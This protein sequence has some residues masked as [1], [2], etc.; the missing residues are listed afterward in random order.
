VA[1]IGRLAP[2][3]A[4]AVFAVGCSSGLLIQ[5]M[6]IRANLPPDL[7]REIAILKEAWRRAPS[8]HYAFSKEALA[9]LNFQPA[10]GNFLKT[11]NAIT[12]FTAYPH[13]SRPL[14]SGRPAPEPEVVE[15]QAVLGVAEIRSVT[16]EPGRNVIQFE[17]PEHKSMK[18]LRIEIF[19]GSGLDAASLTPIGSIKLEDESAGPAGEAVSINPPRVIQNYFDTAVEPRKPYTYRLRAIGRMTTPPDKKIPFIES[20]GQAAFRVVRVPANAQRCGSDSLEFAGAQSAAKSVTSTSNCD[21][22]FSGLIGDISPE[23]IP[24]ERRRTDY[25]ATF[26]VRVW[27]RNEWRSATLQTS[28]GEGLKGTVLIRNME[29]NRLE[30]AEFDT[31]LEFCEVTWGRVRH[32]VKVKEP[33][34]DASGDPKLD[35]VGRPLLETSEKENESSLTEIALVRDLVSGK[36]MELSKAM[37]SPATGRPR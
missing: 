10:D 24:Q 36:L 2:K 18:L 30:A 29:S 37:N 27:M 22:R 20:S 7:S 5:E 1:I 28:P 4:F 21:V 23:G 8:E 32:T 31:G 17:L 33:V 25:K 12:Q 34:L 19:R 15:E 13:P 3:F 11:M 26:S 9:S 35:S 14:V 16:S 6:E